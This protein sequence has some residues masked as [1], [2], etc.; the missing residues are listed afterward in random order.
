MRAEQERAFREFAGE[1]A[2]WLCRSAYLLCGDWR[3]AEDLVQNTLLELYRAWRRV[4]VSTVD[5]YARRTLL[6]DGSVLLHELD[7]VT[8]DDPFRVAT[9]THFMLDGSVTMVSS[10]NYDPVL[11]DQ[12]D[13]NPRPEVAV[14]FDQLDVFATDHDLAFR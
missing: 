14:P 6:D 9:S 4:D 5:S 2:L 7:P 1:R 8:A 3:L 10:C 13:P 11:D 12:Q